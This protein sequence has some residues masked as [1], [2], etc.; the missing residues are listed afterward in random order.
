MDKA[1]LNLFLDEDAA[2]ALEEMAGGERKRSEYLNNLLRTTYAARKASS[3][4]RTMDV[5]ALR[6]TVIGLAGRV[7]AVE[8][9]MLHIQS[10]LAAMIA[11]SGQ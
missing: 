11:N 3:D 5:E 7:Q 4:I 2:Q 9:E 1:R 6:L 8:G 10:Q